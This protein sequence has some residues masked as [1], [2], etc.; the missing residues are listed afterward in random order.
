[1]RTWLKEKRQE[2]QMTQ[3]SV[4]DAIGVSK[5]Y[6]QLIES[7][8]RQQNMSTGIVMGLANCLGISPI[9][10]VEKETSAE[11]SDTCGNSET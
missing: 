3:Q 1:M 4:A 7:G 5:Q 10:I 6:Y 9:E 2:L 8:K 11:V